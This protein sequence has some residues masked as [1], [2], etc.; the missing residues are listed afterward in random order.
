MEMKIRNRLSEFMTK[1]R[2]AMMSIGIII[3][4]WNT[5]WLYSITL[6]A[7][8]ITDGRNGPIGYAYAMVVWS[9]ARLHVGKI[10]I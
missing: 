9:H 1:K 10:P 4:N 5:F 6:V 8:N 3:P 7:F 2:L